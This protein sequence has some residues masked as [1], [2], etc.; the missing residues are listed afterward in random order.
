M[1]QPA[2]THAPVIVWFRDDL[3]L[4]DQPAL[5]AAIR[6]GRPV[7]CLFL[8]DEG[9]SCG[10]ALGG[11][12]NW[13][14]HHALAALDASLQKIGGRLDILVGEHDELPAIASKLGAAEVFWTRR[15]NATQIATDQRV[16]SALT[17]AGIAAGS[18][19][20]QLLREPWEISNKSGGPFRVFTP[21]WKTS[22]AMGD[23][24]APEAAPKKIAAA[25]WPSSAP[26]RVHLNELKLLPTKPDWAGGLEGLNTPAAG[27]ARATLE[28]ATQNKSGHQPRQRSPAAVQRSLRRFG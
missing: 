8:H 9:R 28:N 14:L 4:A 11:A 10:R 6:T 16:K 25:G 26:R 19:N 22:Q 27:A 23:F 5:N 21:F 1:A 20:G 24:A 7:I 12:Q 2:G 15:Y 18:F 13:W 3:R 17:A